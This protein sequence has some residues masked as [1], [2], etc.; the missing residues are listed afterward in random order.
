MGKDFRGAD[1]EIQQRLGIQAK[2]EQAKGAK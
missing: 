1:G 2:E